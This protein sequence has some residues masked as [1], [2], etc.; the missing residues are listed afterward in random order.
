MAAVDELLELYRKLALLRRFDDEIVELAMRRKTDRLFELHT[1]EEAV[2]VGAIHPLR[3]ADYLVSTYGQHRH[4]LARGG[5]T[6]AVLATSRSQDDARPLDADLRFTSGGMLHAI[7]CARMAHHAE[8]VCCIFGDER[9]SYGAFHEALDIAAR[10]S[11]PIV[12]VCENNFYGLGSIFDGAMCQEDLYR[13]AAGYGMPAIRADGMEVLEVYDAVAR[14]A[15]RARAG[16]GSSLVDAVTYRPLSRLATEPLEFRSPHEELIC[17]ARDPL[18][19]FRR[20]LLEALPQIEATLG[21]ID[22]DVEVQI[23]EAFREII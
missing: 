8:I 4:R 21:Q 3:S 18:A 10:E 17:R 19:N 7:E 6:R 9:L 12:F 5:D 1:G 23:E 11:L 20:H 14:A 13:F 15:A 22:R 16:E 2:A